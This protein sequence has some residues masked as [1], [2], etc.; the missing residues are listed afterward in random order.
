MYTNVWPCLA[1]HRLFSVHNMRMYTYVYLYIYCHQGLTGRAY[2]SERSIFLLG[3][4]KSTKIDRNPEIT[5]NQSR[6]SQN[7]QNHSESF[8]IDPSSSKS[9]TIGAILSSSK[10]IFIENTQEKQRFFEI[11]DFSLGRHFGTPFGPHGFLLMPSL[12]LS[13]ALW[14]HLGTVLG[15]LGT[16]LQPPGA[17]LG[18]LGASLWPSWSPLLP[19][20]DLLGH[21]ESTR[22]PYGCHFASFW[23][24]FGSIL[25]PFW[26]HLL[27][28]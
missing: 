7:Q 1:I 3:L 16:I 17:I 20:W 23:V 13:G 10:A 21:L 9:L 25:G 26:I 8:Q 2:H 19:S 14:G 27:A 6:T 24:D 22:S 12:E 15:S 28:F 18:R 5:P 4:A 11:H